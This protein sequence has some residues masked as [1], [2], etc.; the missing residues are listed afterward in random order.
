MLRAPGACARKAA[1]KGLG[2]VTNSE[3]KM[4]KMTEEIYLL[5]VID[6]SIKLSQ[7][8]LKSPHNAGF[9]CLVGFLAGKPL[10]LGELLV[11]L[12]VFAVS[13]SVVNVSLIFTAYGYQAIL[14]FFIVISFGL[15]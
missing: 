4:R 8:I 3:G 2:A 5:C 14:S 12:F 9:F 15:C 7:R 13:H 1:G 11:L 6:K 10:V